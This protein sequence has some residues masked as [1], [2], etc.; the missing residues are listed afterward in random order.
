M[1]ER[2]FLQAERFA[3]A[4]DRRRARRDPGECPSRGSVLS[5][6]FITAA[7]SVID[8]KDVGSNPRR[9]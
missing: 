1:L 8:K 3:L 2:L 7:L 5:T 4:E 6:C 9:L